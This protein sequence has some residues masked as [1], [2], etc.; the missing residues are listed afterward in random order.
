MNVHKC[1]ENSVSVGRKRAEINWFIYPTKI[2]MDQVW[3]ATQ[4]ETN[5]KL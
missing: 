5:S 1:V 3:A 2:I 4:R